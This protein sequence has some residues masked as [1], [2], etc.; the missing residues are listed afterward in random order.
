MRVF[1][2]AFCILAAMVGVRGQAPAD[3]ITPEEYIE[4]NE[5][6]R[7]FWKK[8]L[9]TADV[10]PLIKEYG[11]KNFY[12]CLDLDDFQ[13]VRDDQ[14]RPARQPQVKRLYLAETDFVIRLFLWGSGR[15]EIFITD[16]DE[17]PFVSFP[18][19]VQRAISKKTWELVDKNDGNFNVD[20]PES[21]QVANAYFDRVLATLE[22]TNRVWLKHIS[23][24]TS[25]IASQRLAKYEAENEYAFRPELSDPNYSCER[26]KYIP[27]PIIVDI[28][29]LQMRVWK[30][31]GKLKLLQLPFHIDS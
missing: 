15:P 21:D 12:R 30:V 17:D 24:S 2:L 19:E 25:N 28:P 16:D 10:E 22:I 18:P 27:R 23:R 1:L 14:I 11:E 5:F 26:Q 31:D 4:A 6:A 13:F 7:K 29:F 3:K 20:K 9:V 8:L